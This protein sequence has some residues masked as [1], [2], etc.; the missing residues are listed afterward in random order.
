VAF[1]ISN[2]VLAIEPKRDGEG[3]RAKNLA[4]HSTTQKPSQKGILQLFFGMDTAHSCIEGGV[5]NVP[6]TTGIRILHPKL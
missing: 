4:T 2:A 5:C 6:T 1:N 3:R